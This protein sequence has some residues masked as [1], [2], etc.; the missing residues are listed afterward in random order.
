[1]IQ[2]EVKKEIHRGMDSQIEYRNYDCS[3]RHYFQGK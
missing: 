3:R 2:A 1:M